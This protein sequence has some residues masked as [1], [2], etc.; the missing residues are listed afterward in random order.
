M[1][2][3]NSLLQKN[4]TRADLQQALCKIETEIKRRQE[5]EEE[6]S[7]LEKRRKELHIY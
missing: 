7:V 3:K 2:W 4:T 1:N 6:K 5:L